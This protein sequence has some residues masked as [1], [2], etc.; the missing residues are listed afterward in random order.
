MLIC[1]FLLQLKD[2]EGKE[3]AQLVDRYKFLDMYPCST[4]ELKSIGYSD[5]STINEFLIPVTTTE[6]FFQTFPANW[7]AHTKSSCGNRRS[8]EPIAA[9]RFLANDTIQT[10]GMPISIWASVSWRYIST[11][12]SIGRFMQHTTTT[13]L[14]P[15]SFRIDRCD[16]WHFQS[17]QITRM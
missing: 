1:L 10:E 13:Y 9:T 6:Y 8:G 16:D 2:Y 12:T 14:F 3:T 7:I 4:V 15:W 17:H 11:A 5:V